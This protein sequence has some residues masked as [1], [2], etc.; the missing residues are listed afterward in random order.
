MTAE[1]AH[2]NNNHVS[3]GTLPFWANYG[4]NPTYRGIPL[5]KQ[6]KPAVE[7]RLQMIKQV[8]EELTKCLKQAQETMKVQFDQHI[9]GTPNWNFGD[10]VWLSSKNI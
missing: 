6:G 8:Q 3:T 4:F 9:K 2:N 5:Y 7:E 1:F 10:K